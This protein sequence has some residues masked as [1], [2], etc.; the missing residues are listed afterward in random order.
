MLFLSSDPPRPARERRHGRPWPAGL[1][2]GCPGRAAAAAAAPPGRARSTGPFCHH[3]RAR[4]G[5]SFP[6]QPAQTFMFSEL[7]GRRRKLGAPCPLRGAERPPRRVPRPGALRA[8]R[9]PRRARSH[10]PLCPLGSDR[11]RATRRGDWEPNGTRAPRAPGRGRGRRPGRGPGCPAGVHPRPQAACRHDGGPRGAVRG[12]GVRGE[13][14]GGHA[15]RVGVPG[16]RRE[17]GPQT[18]SGGARGSAR[19]LVLTCRAGVPP[20]SRARRSPRWSCRGPRRRRR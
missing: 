10:G 15:V 8:L 13:G 3:T 9:T 19:P 17:L 4:P 1:C 18:R 5:D 2:P 20:L 12:G 6:P 16:R 14:C 11:P 7:A